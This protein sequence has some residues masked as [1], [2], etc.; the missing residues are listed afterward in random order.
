MAHN[1]L[2][3]LSYKLRVPIDVL[4]ELSQNAEAHYKEFTKTFKNGKVRP[5]ECPDDKLMPVLKAVRAQLL[6]GIP[7]SAIVHGSRKGCSPLSNASQHV[8]APSV[9]SVD[10][11]NFF[12]SVTNKMVYHVF[13]HIVGV[14]PDAAHVLTLL[15]TRNGHLPQGSPTSDALANLF[16]D[17]VDREVEAIA[18][19][20]NLKA[21]RYVDNYDFAGVRAREAIGPTIAALRAMRMA[22]R[23]KKTFNA[24]PRAAHV[25]TGLNVNGARA[26]TS[27]RARDSARIQVYAV[28]AARQRGLNTDI[29]ERSL[30]GRLAQI[31]QTNPRFVV[32]M[33]RQLT[34]AGIDL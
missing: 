2:L 14:G 4:S 11:K 24:G 1:T 26:T 8:K 23:H 30:R 20:L 15:T 9:A 31:G 12:P 16:L 22:V 27:R 6:V 18:E 25:V 7:L 34:S 13:T 32:R 33:K 19:A 28:I 21:T 5:I 17:P 10:V 29:Q 3:W